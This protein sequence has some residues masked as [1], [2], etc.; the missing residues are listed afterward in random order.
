MATTNAVV[1]L[2]GAA[3]ESDDVL[4]QLPSVWRE[5][6]ADPVAAAEIAALLRIDPEQLKSLT[7]PP[8]DVVQDRAGINATDLL[9]VVATWVGT[10]VL[11]KS[12]AD[13]GREAVK[14]ALRTLWARHLK[15][16]L[17]KM[18]AKH[19]ALGDEA[20]PDGSTTNP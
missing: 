16:G 18:Q 8:I 1:K 17:E 13:L 4:A 7:G 6:I 3:V 12:L 2:V 20:D 11:L 19:R 14:D 10:E 15:P 5:R 9:I